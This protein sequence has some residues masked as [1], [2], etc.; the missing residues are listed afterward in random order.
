MTNARVAELTRLGAAE[1][2]RRIAARELTSVA[3]VEACLERIAEREE[4]VRAWAHLDPA[5]ALAEAHERDTASAPRGPLHGVP[6]GVKD[7]V[8]TEG[9][10]T[11]CGTPIHAGRRPAPAA[12]GIPR[13]RAAPP[14]VRR[15][16]A[17]TPLPDSRPAATRPP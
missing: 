11:E 17:T 5:A 6:V 15:K 10:P 13:R 14:P 9:L 8:D 16:T 1:A 4:E 2:A 7:I 3:L 12:A